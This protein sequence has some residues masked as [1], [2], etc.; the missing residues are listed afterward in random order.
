MLTGSGE[1]CAS[2]TFARAHGGSVGIDSNVAAVSA[3]GPRGIVAVAS[4]SFAVEIETPEDY[5]GSPIPVS[6]NYHQSGLAQIGV[7]NLHGFS[8]AGLSTTVTLSGFTGVGI[9]SL[10]V[11]TGANSEA[12][13]IAQTP[14]SIA[15]E[16]LPENRT[17]P[18]IHVNAVRG[19]N[20][21]LTMNSREAIGLLTT[22]ETLI[23]ATN[24]LSLALS[25]AVFNLPT[26]FSANSAAANLFNNQFSNP[27][28]VPLPAGLYLLLVALLSL[29]RQSR[30]R[31]FKN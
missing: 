1:H 17:T 11:S 23:E 19:L 29:H 8:F 5:D 3:D 10:S 27:V 4:S 15:T 25:G 26:G 20:V 6:L 9:N 22:G 28:T 21:N 2:S 18:T 24:S 14:F 13:A 12:F 30:L 7:E 16:Y 31:F